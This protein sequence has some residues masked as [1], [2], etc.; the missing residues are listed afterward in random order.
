M[1]I[2]EDNK[3]AHQGPLDQA[4]TDLRYGGIAVNS[5]PPFIFLSPY[6]TWGGNGEG[7]EFVSGHKDF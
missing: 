5:M 7:R 1:P 4:V 3:K 6:L 2:D